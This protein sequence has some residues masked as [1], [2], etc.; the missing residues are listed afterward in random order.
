[1]M[2][3]ARQGYEHFA[4]Y[5]TIEDRFVGVNLTVKECAKIRS[6]RYGTSIDEEIGN[7]QQRSNYMNISTLGKKYIDDDEIKQNIVINGMSI[8]VAIQTLEENSCSLCA[9]GSQDM[10]SCDI[11]YCDNRDAIK[12]L[13]SKI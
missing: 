7:L 9:Y 13:K 3:T 5:D 8:D 4:I 12:T 10:D 1:M 11:S 6:E 2:I